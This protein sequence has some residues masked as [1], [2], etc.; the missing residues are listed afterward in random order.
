MTTSEQLPIGGLENLAPPST[1][2]AAASPANHSATLD[3][4]EESLTSGGDGRGSL[5]WFAQYDP[6]TSSWRT[7][8]LSLDTLTPSDGSS[9]TW[10]RSGSMRTGLCYPRAPWVPH[11]H[12]NACFSWPTARAQMSRVKVHFRNRREGY[13]LNLEEVVALREADQV[14]GYLNPRWIEW[15][16]GF[17]SGWSRTSSTRSATRSSPRSRSSSARSS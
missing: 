14:N 17:P 5:T 12:A 10:P 9:L 7:S 16:M 6:D 3:Y 13:G 4:A 2:Y 1:S 15:L 11:T 8:Q